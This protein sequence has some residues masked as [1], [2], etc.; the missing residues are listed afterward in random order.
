MR[1]IATIVTNLGA[2]LISLPDCTRLRIAVLGVLILGAG[3]IYKLV[4]SITRLQEPLPIATP[5]QLIK[6]ME[7]LIQQTSAD[8]KYYS[9]T[10]KVGMSQLDSLA[11]VYVKQ[12][13]SSR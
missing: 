8:A 13:S 6:P 4:A 5:D 3:S 10:R 7:Q 11:K 1:R 2:Y 12:N 9:K